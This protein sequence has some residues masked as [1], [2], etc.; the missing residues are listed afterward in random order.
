MHWL[1]AA[2]FNTM[3][4]H[5]AEMNLDPGKRRCPGTSLIVAYHAQFLDQR[6]IVFQL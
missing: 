3:T 1:R 4:V 5:M 6:N 2:V